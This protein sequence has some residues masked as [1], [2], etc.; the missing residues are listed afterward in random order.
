MTTY[1][2]LKILSKAELLEAIKPIINKLY[3]EYNFAEID[4]EE[5]D[6]L[7]IRAIDDLKEE[8]SHEKLEEQIIKL[9]TINI[10]HYIKEKMKDNEV[11]LT[12]INNI[13]GSTYNN[14]SYDELL[15]DLK[16]L[17]KTLNVIGYQTD[18]NMTSLFLTKN[19][20]LN[21][22][23]EKIVN[24]NL[25]NIKKNKVI[26]SIR[27]SLFTDLLLQYC[28]YNDI[29]T[30]DLEEINDEDISLSA[31]YYNKE[32][33]KYKV[34][35]KEEEYEIFMR[36]NQGDEE[37]KKELILHNLRLVRYIAYKYV[38]SAS[39]LSLAD[40]IQEG[41]I[42]LM[43]AVDKFDMSRGCKF[44][45]YAIY[46]ISQKIRRALVEQ[47]TMIRYPVGTSE[48]I[49][50]IIRTQD[51]LLS[52]LGREPTLEEIA[53]KL[54][55]SLEYVQK[56]YDF[57]KI[58]PT[59][60]NVQIGDKEDAELQDMI[61]SDEAVEEEVLLKIQNERILEILNSINL[62]PKELIVIT[63]RMGLD[64]SENIP[65]LEAV[66]NMLG[67]TRERIRQ[68]E[69]RALNK[70]RRSRYIKELAEYNQSFSN[71]LVQ[72][73][74]KGREQSMI[75][76]SINEKFYSIFTKY[77]KEEIDAVVNT[78][79][80]DEIL[81]TEKKIAADNKS[82][83]SK[84]LFK[85]EKEQFVQLCTKIGKKLDKLRLIGVENVK[86]LDTK[87]IKPFITTIKGYS[88]E[89]LD[90]VMASLTEEE[91]SLI[92]KRDN[93]GT[94]KCRVL[95]DDWT[96]EDDNNLQLLYNKIYKKLEDNKNARIKTISVIRRPRNIDK[97]EKKEIIVK[98]V[99][100][101]DKPV[102]SIDKVE[103]KERTMK[104]IKQDKPAKSVYKVLQGTK[105]EIDMVISTLSEDEI[106][107]LH[108]RYGEDL[109][110]P[111][112]STEEWTKEDNSRLY[113]SIFGKMK[114]RLKRL[115]NG[116][117]LTNSKIEI[118]IEKPSQHIDATQT[119]QP[120]VTTNTIIEQP[121]PTTEETID[122]QSKELNKDDYIKMLDLLKTPTF[123]EM[124]TTLS[125]KDAVI[126]SLKLGY[127]D[128]KYFSTESISKFLDISEEEVMETTKKVL[129]L[130]RNN[131]NDFID[132][133]I[134]MTE[135]NTQ[136]GYIKL[137]EKAS[138]N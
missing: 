55:Y 23:I 45:T 61:M 28:A 24:K 128:E 6:D 82:K 42:G 27:D 43:I 30:V 136:T 53:Q 127:V 47:G 1:D 119:A 97:I 3:S 10:N 38:K 89:E 100:Q 32:I 69:K 75:N 35:T 108:K 117:P 105:E 64:G 20:K 78:L 21:L 109:E 87:L 132:K 39:S 33:N 68:I 16:K 96:T 107:L 99:K 77:T 112:I 83:N 125:V 9:A 104:T 59:S 2:N 4:K 106:N 90:V 15:N 37:A 72:E 58:M 92:S 31:D 134:N 102:K 14:D 79:S 103:K 135:S 124:L 50:K 98:P 129:Q 120:V 49:K 63:L 74:K 121:K 118:T 93:G 36:I 22:T 122:H 18:F 114:N 126:I 81:L 62:K 133:A 131:I 137:K 67:V 54:N 65:T 12:I 115:Q 60:L 88:K 51:E 7:V 52:K 26:E 138:Q 86:Y 56:M 41:N 13:F 84:K 8:K 29:E 94:D 48:K 46:W 101:Q 76:E 71:N 70:I 11:A 17:L 5:F 73:T 85:Y 40:L 110:N 25:E 34:L 91:L 80:E 95:P 116:K 113:G 19:E 44:S 57:M 66:G 130:Y 123:S 111:T